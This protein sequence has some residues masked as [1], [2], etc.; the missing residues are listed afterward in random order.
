MLNSAADLGWLFERQKGKE[1][2]REEGGRKEGWQRILQCA[3]IETNVNDYQP[4]TNVTKVNYG[5][6]SYLRFIDGYF[7]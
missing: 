7:G 4:L 5:Y 2:D 6:Y 3:L 1:R